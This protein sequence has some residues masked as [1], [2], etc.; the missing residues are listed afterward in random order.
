MRVKDLAI[1]KVCNNK[2]SSIP[3]KACG[4]NRDRVLFEMQNIKEKRES[5]TRVHAAMIRFHMESTGCATLDMEI[6]D[7]CGHW[8]TNLPKTNPLHDYYERMKSSTVLEMFHLFKFKLTGLT[9]PQ[10]VEQYEGYLTSKRDEI[11]RIIEENE[12]VDLMQSKGLVFPRA[13]CI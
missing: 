7:N 2:S 8:L 13:E 5:Y 3:C 9:R 12:L 4:K 6:L 11:N 1:C 10:F